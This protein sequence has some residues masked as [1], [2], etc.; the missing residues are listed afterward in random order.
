VPLGKSQK[1]PARGPTSIRTENGQL[2]VYV[3]VD[4]RDR[5]IGGYVADASRRV[6]A[7]IQFPPA[8]I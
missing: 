5:D 1:S 7:S 8:P 4:I 2:A 6:Q 3:Y